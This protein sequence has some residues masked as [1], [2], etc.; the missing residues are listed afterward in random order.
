MLANVYRNY[1]YP[2]Y[3]LWPGDER[4]YLYGWDE[5]G[6]ED[7]RDYKERDGGSNMS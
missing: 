7:E 2:S 6:E 3:V 5:E 4:I 1:M